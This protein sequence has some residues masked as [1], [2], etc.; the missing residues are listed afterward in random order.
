M[1]ENVVKR[2]R[3]KSK[4]KTALIELCDEKGFYNVTIWDIC[5]RAG[6]YRSTFYRYYETKDEVLREIEHEYIEATRSL[7]PTLW[8]IHADASPE[9]MAQYRRELTA[10][11]EYHR[12]HKAICK[13]LLSPA[14]DMY[15]YH[16]MVESIGQHM[17]KNFRKY[18]ARNAKN[19]EYLTNF[20]AAGF[21]STIEEWLNQDDFSPSEIASFLLD[22]IKALQ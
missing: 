5:E 15:F 7:T 20:F 10:D 1:A 14:G 18:G 9:E 2:S 6:L 16:K 11:M 3:T 13:F 12:E 21:V 17:K 4:L 8:N 22:M 19:A